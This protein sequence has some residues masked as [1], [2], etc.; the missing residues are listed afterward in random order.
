MNRRMKEYEQLC[1]LGLPTR[2][3]VPLALDLL[4]QMLGGSMTCFVWSDNRC[5]AQD[6]YILEDIPADC[7]RVYAEVF[8]NRREVEMGPRFSDMLRGG[9]ALVNF[10]SFGSKMFNSAMHS[11]LL[12]DY[13]LRH[14]TRVSV[15]D[16]ERRYGMFAFSRGM[17]DRAHSLKEEK[18][19]LH[20]ARHLAYAFA[21]ER[22][23]GLVR[24]ETAD[25]DETG[26]ILL[27]G[28]GR[29]QHGSK[30]G[31]HL[32]QEATRADGLS[33]QAAEIRN[34]LPEALAANARQGQPA[35]EVLIANRRGEFVFRPFSLSSTSADQ[36]ALVA[37]TVRRRGSMATR[38]WQAS[39][40]FNLSG[41]E[42]QVAVLL[43][44]GKRYN[45]IASHLGISRNT[46]ESYVRR[47]YEKLGANQREQLI[48]TLFAGSS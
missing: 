12:K 14:L 2:E 42:R 43:G 28:A 37:V 9:I 19:M 15:I 36:D 40:N 46:A 26:F 6:S 34:S 35:E 30:L 8:Y 22:A 25:N 23:G 24:G 20:A 18:L 27:D 45:E 10:S 29:I 48:R 41:R 1:S 39:R 21:L 5:E 3:V 13:G 31:L 11:E 17:G 16:G 32:F 7:P 47:T 44:V 33:H 4:Q 38:L